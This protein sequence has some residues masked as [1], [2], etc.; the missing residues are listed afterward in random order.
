MRCGFNI[1]RKPEFDIDGIKETVDLFILTPSKQS[2]IV[3]CRFV[4]EETSKFIK[5][6]LELFT[7]KKSKINANKA[8]VISKRIKDEGSE[9]EKD[10]G[11]VS[12]MAY[13]SQGVYYWDFE[14][15]KGL[16]SLPGH[17]L[18]SKVGMLLNLEAIKKEDRPLSSVN[19]E[20]ESYGLYSGSDIIEEK[21]TFPLGRAVIIVV[22]AALIVFGVFF[23]Y[24]E[25][26]A[27]ALENMLGLVLVV[28]FII[29]LGLSGDKK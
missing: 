26:M 19:L 15:F 5:P 8:L 13:A 1:K 21:N 20:D 27:E 23:D 7:D 22:M 29:L 14:T 12:Y 16:Y 17:D 18:R 3:E 24:L 11:A 6:L 2:I 10:E 9:A 4:K 25:G 28:F